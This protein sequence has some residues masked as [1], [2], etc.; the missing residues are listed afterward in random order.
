MIHWDWLL[1]LSIAWLLFELFAQP[2][3][4]IAA[5]SLKF[6]LDDFLNGLWL[7]RKDPDRGRGRTC[8]MFYVAAGFWQ[9]TVMT[10][11]LSVLGMMLVV[12]VDAANGPQPA[13]GAEEAALGAGVSVLI[14]GLCFVSS[15]VCTWL[16][17]VLA[18]RYRV[19][20]WLDGSLRYARRNGDWPPYSRGTNRVGRVVT[21][22]LIFFVLS[23]TVAGIF[24]LMAIPGAQAMGLGWTVVSTLICLCVSAL[25]GFVVRGWV[26]HHVTAAKPAD[27]WGD[28]ADPV[29]EPEVIPLE[30]A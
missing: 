18:R 1:V 8:G 19:K 30:S 26:E 7:W 10:L 28:G 17:L 13:D 5:A 4:S 11:L 24:A 25:F 2:V 6:G 21:S 9:I 3:L 27:C 14:V 22:A 23:I 12:I 20:V 29:F 16:A 15:S